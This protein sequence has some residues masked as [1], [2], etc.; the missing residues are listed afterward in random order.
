MND[1]G[2]VVFE[3]LLLLR[4]AVAQEQGTNIKGQSPTRSASKVETLALRSPHVWAQE[5]L[6]LTKRG[7]RANAF[8]PAQFF[9]EPWPKYPVA[10]RDA[11]QH[12]EA[13]GNLFKRYRPFI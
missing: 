6:E 8:C 4:A 5:G 12:F 3:T 13:L 2:S 11:E 10:S 1:L 7:F 9:R